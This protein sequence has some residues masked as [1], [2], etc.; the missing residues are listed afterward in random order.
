MGEDI[1]DRS[2]RETEIADVYRSHW[3]LT[4]AASVKKWRAG[5]PAIPLLNQSVGNEV[6]KKGFPTT[7]LQNTEGEVEEVVLFSDLN[8]RIT[9]AQANRQPLGMRPDL[10]ENQSSKFYLVKYVRVC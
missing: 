10:L 7:P 6:N 5:L 1:G 3:F 8:A 4:G 9:T 2:L